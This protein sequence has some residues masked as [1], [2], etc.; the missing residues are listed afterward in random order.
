MQSP[1][2]SHVPPPCQSSGAFSQGTQAHRPSELLVTSIIPQHT[3]QGNREVD[4]KCVGPVMAEIRQGPGVLGGQSTAQRSLAGGLSSPGLSP[5][6]AES[7]AAPAPP[8]GGSETAGAFPLQGPSTVSLNGSGGDHTVGLQEK[9][10]WKGHH[11]VKGHKNQTRDVP[12][13][14]SKGD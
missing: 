1:G 9:Q 11:Q 3:F 10:P 4:V 12:K 13:I 8:G 6:P 2:L 7:P 5:R 14:H